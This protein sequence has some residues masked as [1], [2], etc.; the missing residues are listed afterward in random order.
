MRRDCFTNWA[1]CLLA[2]L[3]TT[4]LQICFTHTK[5]QLFIDEFA[6]NVG[7]KTYGKL[8]MIGAIII[9]REIHEQKSNFTH[10]RWLGNREPR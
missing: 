3:W 8:G 1:Y 10:P 2:F 5:E 4:F 6:L 9:L 7:I